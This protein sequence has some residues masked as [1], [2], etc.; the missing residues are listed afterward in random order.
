MVGVEFVRQALLD[1]CKE[2]S[3]LKLR[4]ANVFSKAHG[5]YKFVLKGGALTLL[6]G[7]IFALPADGSFQRVWGARAPGACRSVRPALTLVL[8]Q[9]ALRWWRWTRC[10]GSGTWSASAPPWRRAASCCCRCCTARRARRSRSRAARPSLFRRRRSRRC[11]AGACRRGLDCK[12][13]DCK[14]GG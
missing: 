1:F 5:P 3:E 6:C 12:R 4:R 9:T 13:A 11:T 8:P 14:R 10:S 2:H 7:D